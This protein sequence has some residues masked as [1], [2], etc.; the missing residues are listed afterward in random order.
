MG[1]GGAA[2]GVQQRDEVGVGGHVLV[3][4]GLLGQADGQ[5]TRAQRV[6]ERLAAAEVG[7]DR[8]G[9]RELGRAEPSGERV[10]HAARGYACPDGGRQGASGRPG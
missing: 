8:E 9:G 4:A 2:R 6:L 3:E 7:G 5:D 10:S 1:V